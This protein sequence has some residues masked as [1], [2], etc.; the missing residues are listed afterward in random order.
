VPRESVAAVLEAVANGAA[1]SA[2]PDDIPL[3]R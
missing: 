2:V 1:L 3:A